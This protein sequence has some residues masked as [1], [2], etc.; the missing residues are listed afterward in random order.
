MLAMWHPVMLSVAALLLIGFLMGYKLSTLTPGLSQPEFATYESAHSLRVIVDNS[1]N[2]PYKTLVYIA[3]SISKSAL[4]LRSVNAALGGLAIVLFYLFVRKLF[5]PYVAFGTT[6]LFATSSLFLI[7]ARHAGSDIMLFSLLALTAAGYLIRFHENNSLAWILATTIVVLSLYVPG[8]IIF[9][10]LGALWQFNRARRSFEELKPSSII[11]CATILAVLAAPLVVSLIRSPEL[12][13]AYLGLPETLAS[14]SDMGRSV[15]RGLSMLF[16]LAP[17]DPL[18]SVGRQPVLDVFATAMF[19]YGLFAL[20]R[21]YR[22]DRL[23]TFLGIFVIS[24]AW[25]GA[26]TNYLGIAMLLPFVYII[27]GMGI[28]KLI[29]QWLSVFPRNPIARYTGSALMIIA[30]ALS[31]NFQL[32]RYFVAWPNNQETKQAFERSLPE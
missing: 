21:Q 28:D 29:G 11:L 13:R 32:Q 31:I 2:A 10:V 19:I 14:F 4:A 15:G 16:V 20:M 27:V 17:A 30:L 9:I 18:R 25:V 8:M 22:L 26:T 7:T 24:L 3:T 6:L 1:V 5:R 23:W 12:W